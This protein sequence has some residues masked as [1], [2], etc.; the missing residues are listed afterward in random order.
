MEPATWVFGVGGA[1]L[2]LVVGWVLA[3]RR[4][5]LRV[6]WHLH[7]EAGDKTPPDGTELLPEPEPDPDA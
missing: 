5:R 4:G 1:L 3:R 2:G 6:D 7:V